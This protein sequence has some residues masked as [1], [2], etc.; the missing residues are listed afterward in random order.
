V[1]TSIYCFQY[2]ENDNNYTAIGLRI[3]GK[4]FEEYGGQLKVFYRDWT[5]SHWV[6]VINKVRAP[7][8]LSYAKSTAA[9]FE[10]KTYRKD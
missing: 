6:N 2:L 8:L 5:K 3:G 7:Y 9:R 1:I 10:G 4:Y